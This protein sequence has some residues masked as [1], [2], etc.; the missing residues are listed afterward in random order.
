MRTPWLLQLFGLEMLEVKHTNPEN[1]PH[2]FTGARWLI[3]K[4]SKIYDMSKPMQVWRIR[5]DDMN[6]NKPLIM[7]E[8]TEWENITTNSVQ[9]VEAKSQK[10]LTSTIW[11]LDAQGG[12]QNV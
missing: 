2:S 6:S 9:I 10:L 5:G 11:G 7:W 1:N 4:K 12:Q 8:R 3:R